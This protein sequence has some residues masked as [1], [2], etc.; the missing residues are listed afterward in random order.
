MATLAMKIKAEMRM[1]ELL[2][3]QG[4]P[5]PDEVEYGYGCVRLF[6]HGSKTCVIVDI[7]DDGEIGESR[8]GAPPA[9]REKNPADELFHFPPPDETRSN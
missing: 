1:R 3:D 2:E 4:V 7:D 9:P 8:A 5:L 6:W